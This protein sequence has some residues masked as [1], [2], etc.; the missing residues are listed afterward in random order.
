M[1][2]LLT[3]FAPFGGEELNP[4][5]EAVRRLDG[6]RLGDLPVVAAQ[7]PTEFGA[8][9]R[10]LDELLDRYRPTL[11]V[12][13][14]QAGGRAELSLERIAINVDDARIPDNVGRQ[15]ID[16]PVVPGGPAAYFST[17]PIKA[18]VH[19]LR[20]A[21]FPAAVSQTAGTFVCNHV[22]YGLQHRLQGTGVR[23]GFIHIPYL[24]A[25]AANQPGAPSMALETLVA[26]LR[27]ALTCAATTTADL[28]EGGG[29]LD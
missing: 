21:G 19:A 25:Q 12:A 15:P 14:G 10:V 27:L 7:L 23:G 26:G 29:Q 17:L 20:A 22:F 4:S 11:V 8:A 6:E 13:V 16:E 28:R 24:P 5:W 3:G 18:M 2:L 9:L 1:T